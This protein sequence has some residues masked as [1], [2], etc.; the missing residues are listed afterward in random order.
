MNQAAYLE[1]W[2]VAVNLAAAELQLEIA[3]LRLASI[4]PAAF[5]GFMERMKRERGKK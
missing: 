1:L 2:R 4:S 5:Y 3:L